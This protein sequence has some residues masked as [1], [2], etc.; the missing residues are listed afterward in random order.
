MSSILNFKNK[1]WSFIAIAWL[2]FVI[3][4]HF[5][6]KGLIMTKKDLATKSKPMQV[7]AKN[8]SKQAADGANS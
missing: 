4:V 3:Q 1:R 5:T 8:K 6:F 2:L 7:E